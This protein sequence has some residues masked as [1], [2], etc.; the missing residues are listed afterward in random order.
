MHETAPRTRSQ[1]LLAAAEAYVPGGVNSGRRRTTPA[2]IVKRAKGAY[3]EDVDGRRYI[4]YTGAAGTAILGYSYPAV[5]DKVAET[6]QDRVLFAI[7]STELEIELARKVSEHVPSIEQILLCNSGSEATLNA[8]RLARAVTGRDA[9]IKFQGNYHGFHDYLLMNNQSDPD[10]VN[11]PDPGSAGILGA[12]AEQTLICRYNDLD[13]VEQAFASR[14]DNVAALFVEPIAH[15]APGIMPEPGFLEGVR[16][17][18]DSN[19]AL[20]IFDEVITGFRHHLGGYQA[21]CGVYPDLTVMGK[22]IANGFPVAVLGGKRRLMERFNTH[23]DGDV[24]WAGTYN[25]SQVGVAAA[26]ATIDVLESEP[27]HEHLFRLG[28][29]MRAGL[30]RVAAERSVPVVACGYG[31]LF[32]LLFMEG[33]VGSYDDV[34]RNDSALFVRYRQQMIARGHLEVPD[35]KNSRSHISYSH[36]E[37]DVDATLEAAQEA[38]DAAMSR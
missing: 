14:P 37:A 34:L 27:V 3:L 35:A 4:D 12:A 5:I 20:L 29:R 9:L 24:V 23:P 13:S 8:A 7:G 38:L 36:T 21:V 17:L 19:G 32:A 15:N 18:C 1:E 16:R 6:M 22:A 31:S 2:L 30:A 11:R 10:R 33:P 28:E 25:G 26:L